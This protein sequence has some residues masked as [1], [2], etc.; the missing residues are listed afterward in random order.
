MSRQVKLATNVLGI[1]LCKLNGEW[2]VQGDP[3]LLNLE[4]Q[5]HQEYRWRQNLPL[6]LEAQYYEGPLFCDP[7]PD[8]WMAGCFDFLE[9]HTPLRHVRSGLIDAW[10]GCY[11][12]VPEADDPEAGAGRWHRPR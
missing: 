4:R 8:G 9:I 11:P 10:I 2:T 1:R 6:R 3:A 7:A 12:D 5:V